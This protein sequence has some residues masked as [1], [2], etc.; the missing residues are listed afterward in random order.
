MPS[1]T[2]PKSAIELLEVTRNEIRCRCE[3]DVL[4]GAV[5]P[6]EWLQETLD[7]LNQVIE[8]LSDDGR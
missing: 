7:N 2:R 1:E 3:L 4:T 5:E 6:R 8:L